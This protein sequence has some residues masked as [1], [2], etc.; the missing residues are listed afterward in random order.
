MP[1]IK[2]TPCF[3]D[4]LL[5]L[6]PR[7]RG[8]RIGLRSLHRL[9]HAILP[10]DRRADL[11]LQQVFGNGLRHSGDVEANRIYGV[12]L[13]LAG[14]EKASGE[15]CRVLGIYFCRCHRAG[16]VNIDTIPTSFKINFW[17]IQIIIFN[18]SSCLEKLCFFKLSCCRYEF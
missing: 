1:N 13:L 8:M 16:F 14:H 7:R 5:G 4:V 15:G 6:R 17:I 3:R 10:Q 12:S 2:V 9:L 18:Y 11:V